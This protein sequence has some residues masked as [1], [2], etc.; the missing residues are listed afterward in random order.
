MF[1][2]IKVI[3]TLECVRS[4]IPESWANVWEST[5]TGISPTKWTF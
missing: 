1:E 2:G 5:L 3:S 4:F